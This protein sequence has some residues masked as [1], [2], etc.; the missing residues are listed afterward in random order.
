MGLGSNPLL[1]GLG[2]YY[3]LRRENDIVFHYL[4][5][6]V[7]LIYLINLESM[8]LFYIKN[9]NFPISLYGGSRR[10]QIRLGIISFI[11]NLN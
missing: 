7:F 2:T 5:L 11:T 1:Q 9:N 10:V 6:S 4:N 8:D 3:G